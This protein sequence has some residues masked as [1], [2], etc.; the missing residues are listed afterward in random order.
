MIYHVNEIFYSLQGEGRWAGTPMTFIRF[1]GC[2]LKCEFCDTR[3]VCNFTTIGGEILSKVT[4]F[5][6]KRIVLTGGEPLMQDLNPLCQLLHKAHLKIHLETNGTLPLPEERPDWIS[7]SPKT[8]NPNLITLCDADEVKFLVD[9]TKDWQGYVE[10]IITNYSIIGKKLLLPVAKNYTNK[11]IQLP[12]SS[13][14]WKNI[15]AAMDYCKKNP[16]FSL[17][18]QMQKLLNIA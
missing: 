11:S 3:D 7:V 14:I 16:S 17:C 10:Y 15:H 12:A 6:S 13:L 18:M 1:Q 9:T 2:N 5:P 8:N 4:T